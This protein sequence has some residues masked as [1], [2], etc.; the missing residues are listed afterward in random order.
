MGRQKTVTDW[1]VYH[2]WSGMKE[3]CNP[4]IKSG[5]KYHAG[6]GIRVCPEWQIYEN[7]E[8]WALDNGYRKDLTLDRKDGDDDYYPDNC[9]WVDA[10]TQANNLSETAIREREARRELAKEKPRKPEKPKKQQLE[11]QRF[12]EWYADKMKLDDVPKLSN[13]F[14][15]TVIEEGCYIPM[16]L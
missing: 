11:L 4:N 3:R 9:R 2:R 13:R 6:K 8:K 5:S 12:C 7:F 10:K 16:Y 15:R 1:T 14:M